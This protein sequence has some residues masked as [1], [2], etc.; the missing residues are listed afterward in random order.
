MKE[1]R[2]SIISHIILILGSFVMLF[3]M[4]WLFSSAFKPGSE[5]FSSDFK[6]ISN[7]F[8]FQNFIDGWNIN[9]SYSFGYFL[10]N[11]FLLVGLVILG[12]VLSSSLAAFAFG[13]LNFKFKG[14][15]F[16]FM[17][18]TM[19]LPAQVTLIPKYLMFGKIGW[20]DSYLPFIV[21]AFCAINGFHVFLIVQFIR[22]IPKDL[23]EA[24]YIDGCNIFGI[25]RIIIMPL[26]K[27]V[28]F[29]VAIFTFIWTWDD[30]INQLIYISS[31]NKFT[32]SLFLRSLIDSTSSVSWG[33]LLANTLV[34]LI[35]SILIFFIAQPYFVEGI[36]TTGLKG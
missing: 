8:T 33:P 19:M 9:P 28:L 26:C 16:M 13:R 5:I 31:V 30:Y 17:L 15:L 36:A 35:P 12:T 25:Y 27:P 29:S 24:A 7:N 21:P 6:L 23:D 22:G 18:A 10:G 20:V 3:P 4:I 14:I 2:K 34:S 1:S 32:V 11:T